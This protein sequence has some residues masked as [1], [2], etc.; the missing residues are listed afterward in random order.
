MNKIIKF[1][2]GKELIFVSLLTL[3]IGGAAGFFI[4]KSQTSQPAQNRFQWQR[5][6]HFGENN[7]NTDA[8]S[9]ATGGS[10]GQSWN[11][12]NSATTQNSDES[13]TNAA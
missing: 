6:R 8:N 1:F 10:N 3:I 13:S 12:N 9:G 4:G 5:Q 2:K 7:G 11:S